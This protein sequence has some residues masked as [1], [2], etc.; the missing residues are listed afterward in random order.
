MEIGEAVKAITPE[1]LER[2]PEIQWQAI[3]RMRDHLVH[4]YFETDH[5]IVDDVVHNELNPLMAAVRFLA[6]ELPE[7]DPKPE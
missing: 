6:Q 4:R 1:L 2:R 3:A 5:S 7:S